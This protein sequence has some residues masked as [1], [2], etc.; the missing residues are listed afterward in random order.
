MREPLEQGK[1]GAWLSIVQRQ[2]ASG[3]LSGDEADS[4][5]EGFQSEVWNNTQPGE[6]GRRTVVETGVA[7]L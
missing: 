1:Y 5:A 7:K 4:S 2:A 3:W 6:K